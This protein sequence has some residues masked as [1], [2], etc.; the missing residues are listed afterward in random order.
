MKKC[1]RCVAAVVLVGSVL[2]AGGAQAAITMKVIHPF[3]EDALDLKCS[4]AKVDRWDG[5]TWNDSLRYT[6]TLG[7]APDSLVTQLVINNKYLGVWGPFT[8]ETY[9]YTNGIVTKDSTFNDSA[10]VKWLFQTVYNI[11]TILPSGATSSTI[12]SAVEQYRIGTTSTYQNVKRNFKWNGVV[13]STDTTWG[14]V[15][16][17]GTINWGTAHARDTYT[18]TGNTMVIAEQMY[19]GS[20]AASHRTTLDHDANGNLLNKVVQGYNAGS[21]INLERDSMTVSGNVR[22][23]DYHFAWSGT[24]W[25][26]LYRIAYS[27]NPPTGTC[28]PAAMENTAASLGLSYVVRPQAG[29]IDFSLVTADGERASLEVYDLLGNRCA[30]LLSGAVLGAGKH[31]VSWHPSRALAGPMSYICRAV[32][33]E[34]KLVKQFVVNQ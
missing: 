25:T 14:P 6:Y 34:R 5:A 4:Y 21:P 26:L 3:S 9:T 16:G 28:R 11:G 33:G 17:T 18:P 29:S 8:K 23:A 2:V 27:S 15:R 31:V 19:S 7:P 13:L 32:V 12:T 10:N 24:A 30:T 1:A 20:W 22:T